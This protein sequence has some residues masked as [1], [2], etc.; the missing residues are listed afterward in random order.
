MLF[1]PQTT[2]GFGKG[3]RN[4]MAMMRTAKDQAKVRVVMSLF[5]SSKRRA[6]YRHHNIYVHTHTHTNTHQDPT[7]MNAKLIELSK[8]TDPEVQVSVCIYVCI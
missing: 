4:L 2:A 7:R 5:M 6:E 8:S 3:L 1:H